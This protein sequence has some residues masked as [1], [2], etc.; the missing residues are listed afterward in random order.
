MSAPLYNNTHRF[1]SWVVVEKIF[2]LIGL[3]RSRAE[4]ARELGWSPK[5]AGILEYVEEEI[6][7][8]LA[9]QAQK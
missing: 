3:F 9:R 8:A 2:F 4:R 5:K 6:T 1:F 7:D